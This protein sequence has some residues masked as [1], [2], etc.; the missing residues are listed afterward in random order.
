MM[1]FMISG[2]PSPIWRPIR[3]RRRC[4]KGASSPN[5]IEERAPSQRGRHR[6]RTLVLFRAEAASPTHQAG[7]ASGETE[8]EALA[9]ALV[10]LLER[11]E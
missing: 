5:V 9:A 6:Y 4:S 10:R 7:R 1:P 3:S 2:V 11:G 8:A